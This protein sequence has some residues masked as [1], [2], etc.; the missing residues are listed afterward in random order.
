MAAWLPQAANTAGDL[1][2]VSEH[3]PA[4][5]TTTTS[6]LRASFCFLEGRTEQRRG[7]VDLDYERRRGWAESGGCVAR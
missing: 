4:A 5:A 1:S 3:A 2:L 6:S 7:P